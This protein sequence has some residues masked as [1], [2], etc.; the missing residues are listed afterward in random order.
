MS[1]SRIFAALF[2]LAL[3]GFPLA[4]MLTGPMGTLSWV[5]TGLCWVTAS[6]IAYYDVYKGGA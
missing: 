3:V 2:V 4:L 5:Y 1:A 6:I